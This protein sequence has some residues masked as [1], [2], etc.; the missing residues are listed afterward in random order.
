VERHERTLCKLAIGDEAFMDGIL[1]AGHAG[2][3]ELD[4][5]SAALVRLAALV[6]IDAA[7]PS[8]LH[9]VEAALAAGATPDEIVGC[10]VAIMPAVGTARIVD[11]APKVGLALGYDVAEALEDAGAA[12]G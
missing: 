4:A 5:K 3:P 10:L 9:P 11:A 12:A 2:T 7:E 8:Y 1:A 6:A